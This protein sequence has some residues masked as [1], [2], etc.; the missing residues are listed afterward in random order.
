M[1]WMKEKFKYLSTMIVSQ[2]RIRIDYQNGN[3]M[4]KHT[5]QNKIL[6]SILHQSFNHIYL[7]ATAQGLLAEKEMDL[8]SE[9][10]TILVPSS[11]LWC[12]LSVAP[13]LAFPWTS[14]FKCQP[15]HLYFYQDSKRTDVS[16]MWDYVDFISNWNI[17]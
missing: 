9:C 6:I 12:F 4:A 7:M 10:V 17:L 14:A 11:Y 16:R 15:H 8:G 13:L 3:H 5:L 2:R 1:N